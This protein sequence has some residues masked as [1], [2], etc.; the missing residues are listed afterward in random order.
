MN[1]VHAVRR[2][3]ALLLLVSLWP[4]ATAT[5]AESVS[6]Q[7]ALIPE[8]LGAGTTIEFSFQI[9]TPNDSLPPPLIALN[10]SYPANLGIVTSGLGIATCDIATLEAVGPQGCPAD[11]LMGHGSVLVEI[12]IGPEIIAETGHLTTWMAPIEDGHLSLLFYADGE[13]PVSAEVLFNSL[14][15]EAPAPYGGQLDTEIPEIPGLPGGSNPTI[16]QMHA[17]IGPKNITYYQRSGG[18]TIAYQPTGLLLPLRCPHGGFPFAATFIFLG[19]TS[20]EARTTVPC[21]GRQ[22]HARRHQDG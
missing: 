19:G 7:A 12:P 13:T 4:A 17:T 3:A 21:P 20:N 1:A 15:L 11:S 16:V 8:R 9:A 2:L 18:R 5:A 6:L 10:L 14:L 22:P